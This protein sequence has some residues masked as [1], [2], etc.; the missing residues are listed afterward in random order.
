M[1]ANYKNN[2][3]SIQKILDKLV[4]KTNNQFELKD[5]TK[6]D[7]DNLIQ[8]TKSIIKLFYYKS[9]LDFQKLLDMAKVSPKIHIT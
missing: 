1:N 9:I 4:I 6:K 2:I 8:E 7:L 5:I 3:A